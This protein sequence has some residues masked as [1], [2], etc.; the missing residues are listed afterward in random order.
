MSKKQTDEFVLT[1][2]NYYTEE[3]SEHYLSFHDFLNYIRFNGIR[4]CEARAE[5][6]RKGEWEREEPN[7]AMLV[8]SYVDAA[9]EGTLDKFRE[10]HPEIFLK[11]G[12]TLAKDFRVA[13][14]MIERMKKDDYFMSTLSGE[15]QVIMTAYWEGVEWRCKMD[16]YI[17]GKAIVDL[18]TTSDIHK[19]W[20]V[21]DKGYLTVPEYWLYTWQLAMYQNIVYLNTGQKLPC[22]LSFVTKEDFPE[23]LVVNIDQETLD[24][25]L[26]D[27]KEMLPTVLGIRKGEIKPIR[28]GECDYCKSTN[29]LSGAIGI[30][31]LIKE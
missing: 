6:I 13:E 14:T 17:P 21:E 3:A 25:S 30:W 7:K 20:R 23:L 4:N 2:D 9:V 10:E 22:Y 1:N 11:D 15:K 24:R 12:K 5:A 19:V 29:K 27:I 28:C 18:K 8:G 16:S 26:E 31:D